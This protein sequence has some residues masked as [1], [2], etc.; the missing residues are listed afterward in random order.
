MLAFVFHPASLPVYPFESWGTVV[1]FKNPAMFSEAISNLC[2][3]MVNKTFTYFFSF[4][5][6]IENWT[7]G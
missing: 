2:G 7:L 6:L 3:E 5:F 1:L 4:S